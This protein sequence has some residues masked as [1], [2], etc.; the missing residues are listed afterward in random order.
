VVKPF[1]KKNSCFLTFLG[2][3]CKQCQQKEAKCLTMSYFI[4]PTS[5]NF[6]FL[7]FDKIQDGAQNGGHLE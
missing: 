6:Y 2:E 4:C 7:V 5:E 1:W 3:K